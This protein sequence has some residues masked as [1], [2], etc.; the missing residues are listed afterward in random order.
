M[1]TGGFNKLPVRLRKK[2]IALYLK[3]E[4]SHTRSVQA[5]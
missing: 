4:K 1:L 2:G 3:E 5:E